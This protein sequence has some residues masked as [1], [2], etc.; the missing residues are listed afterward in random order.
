MSICIATTL[1]A[2]QIL[3]NADIGRLSHPWP[4]D[5]GANIG[6][7]HIFTLSLERH[8]LFL[9]L[10]Y[11]AAHLCRTLAKAGTNVME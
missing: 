2:M 4:K 5:N 6:V 8:V 3:G 1:V 7:L 11:S 9:N 10:R